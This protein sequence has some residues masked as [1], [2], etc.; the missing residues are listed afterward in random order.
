MQSPLS[1]HL[2]IYKPQLTSVLSILHRISG[3]GFV[4]G[5]IVTCLWLYSLSSG[6][7]SYSCFCSWLEPVF[8]KIGFYGILACVYY[9]FLNGIRYLVWSLGKGYD[10]KTVYTSGW[11]VVTLVFVLIILTVFYL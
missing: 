2:Q 8:V 5:L 6:Q 9:H 4:G 3:I 7:S 10:L 1:P 11:T